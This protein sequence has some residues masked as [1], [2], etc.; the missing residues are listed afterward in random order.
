MPRTKLV[1]EGTEQCQFCLNYYTSQRMQAHQTTS[2][3]CNRIREKIARRE[4]YAMQRAN[5]LAQVRLASDQLRVNTISEQERLSG[6]PTTTTSSLFTGNTGEPVPRS[7]GDIE[8]ARLLDLVHNSGPS[9]RAAAADTDHEDDYV[10]PPSPGNYDDG[11]DDILDMPPSEIEPWNT[12]PPTAQFPPATVLIPLRLAHRQYNTTD[13]YVTFAR[14]A[15]AASTDDVSLFG[16]DDMS[17]TGS[18]DPNSD[19]GGKPIALPKR[20]N[21]IPILVMRSILN[22]PAEVCNETIN[23]KRDHNEQWRLWQQPQPATKKEVALLQLAN[24][25]ESRG[26]S[27][28]VFEEILAWVE[29]M[30]TTGLL[31]HGDET[32]YIRKTKRKTFVHRIMQMYPTAHFAW[33]IVAL[34]TKKTQAI[35]HAQVWFK[36]DQS[37]TKYYDDLNQFQRTNRDCAWVPKTC[38]AEQLKHLLSDRTLFGNLD[39]LVLNHSNVPESLFMP[40]ENGPN[41]RLDDILSGSWYADTVRRMNLGKNDFLMPILLYMDKTGTDAYQRYGLEPVIFSVAI[42]KRSARNVSSSWRSMGFIPDL[43]LRSK[44]EKNRDRSSNMKGTSNRNYQQILRVVLESLSAYQHTGIPHQFNLGPYRRSVMLWPKVCL[45]MGDA[46]SGDCLTGRY[47]T[48]DKLVRRQSR[49]CYTTFNHLDVPR[50]PCQM[51]RTYQ[52]RFLTVLAYANSAEMEESAINRTVGSTSNAHKRKQVSVADDSSSSVIDDCLGSEHSDASELS[53]V[54]TLRRT[55]AQNMRTMSRPNYRRN[56]ASLSADSSSEACHL[57]TGTRR[58]T[59]EP[60]A[61]SDSEDNQTLP[62]ATYKTKEMPAD[63]VLSTNPLLDHS[64]VIELLSKHRAERGDDESVNEYVA[65]GCDSLDEA[66]TDFVWKLYQNEYSTAA[67]AQ[68]TLQQLSQHQSMLAF[69]EIDFGGD[70][71]GIN[72][73]TPT[74]VMHSMKLGLLRYVAKWLMDQIKPAQKAIL[75]DLAYTVIARQRQTESRYYPRTNFSHSVTGIS[76]LTA[77]E[78]VG[79][80]FTM[81]I[82]LQTQRG[83]TAF[84][85]SKPNLPEGN[86]VMT[87]VNMVEMIL[88]CLTWL[89][90]G[91]FWQASAPEQAAVAAESIDTMIQNMVTNTPRMEGNGWCIIKL[92]DLRHICQQINKFGSPMNWDSST[93]ERNLKEHAK[94]PAKTAQMR[95]YKTFLEQ[96]L[97]RTVE[98]QALAM[99]AE[100]WRSNRQDEWDDTSVNDCDNLVNLRPNR[101]G[102]KKTIVKLWDDLMEDTMS[103]CIFQYTLVIDVTTGVSEAVDAAPRRGKNSYA[104]PAPVL[105]AIHLEL[106]RIA[107]ECPSFEDSDD[108]A[109]EEMLMEV[110]INIYSEATLCHRGENKDLPMGTN[111][112]RYADICKRGLALRCHPNYAQDGPWNDWVAIRGVE[113]RRVMID[114]VFRGIPAKIHC[115]FTWHNTKNPNKLKSCVV[116]HPA[117]KMKDSSVLTETWQMKYDR[118]ANP[119]RTYQPKLTVVSTDDIVDRLYAFMEVRNII[120]PFPE[121]HMSERNI[122]I[123]VKDREKWWASEFT[124]IY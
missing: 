75:D 13:D 48:H 3:N 91:P 62:L 79:V 68:S 109:C 123:V 30:I 107:T 40:Y 93:G 90:L 26:T 63:K 119:A 95:G 50:Y 59:A 60:A 36:S 78:W 52:L 97:K 76:M 73:C 58:R 35:L 112:K 45:V 38:F 53:D 65:T 31:K 55:S 108:D 29:G 23:I 49:H 83:A 39:N 16:D 44:A 81:T 86:D 19:G 66:D 4:E 42:L 8:R 6:R 71:Y 115:M 1:K 106:K 34:E 56:P 22:D 7:L 43:E 105:A 87:V 9:A 113:E 88:S 17:A 33:Q 57:V 37:L 100:D 124:Q 70:A 20:P 72:G 54:R 84:R 18:V 122:A 74:D 41:D 92:H 47:G 69:H 27:H 10:H 77:D 12:V 5:A 111:N 114:S 21:T 102:S 80:L 67:H 118:V 101:T 98:R 85:S 82:L 11:A 28:V 96:T 32:D 103:I 116:V 24:L 46:K 120:D 110:Q 117:F 61:T 15:A 64:H 121:Q 2:A 89:T 14:P 51:I 94:N 25:L 104:P 99:A